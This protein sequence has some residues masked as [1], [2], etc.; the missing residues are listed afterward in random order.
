[1]A[2]CGPASGDLWD[3]AGDSIQRMRSVGCDWRG[4]GV[5]AEF[6]PSKH[7]GKV[8]A[9]LK[10]LQ[11]ADFSATGLEHGLERPRSQLVPCSYRKLRIRSNE[12]LLNY[13]KRSVKLYERDRVTSECKI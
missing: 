4:R 9:C 6:L 7:C 11:L 13:I 8:F 3:I 12:I 1:M 2:H 5:P 10:L